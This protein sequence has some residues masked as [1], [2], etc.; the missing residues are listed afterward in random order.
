M[1]Q[2]HRILVHESNKMVMGLINVTKYK[3]ANYM[4]LFEYGKYDKRISPELK[5][6]L[7]YFTFYYPYLYI[8]RL[9]RLYT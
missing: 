4:I 3:N 7:S 9:Y 6:Y 2:L 5:L 1:M 8:V